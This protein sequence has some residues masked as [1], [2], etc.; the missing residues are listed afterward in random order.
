VCNS[1]EGYAATGSDGKIVGVTFVDVHAKGSKVAVLG[2][3]AALAPGTGKKTFMAACAHAEKL[4]FS[5][6]IL[7][8]VASNSR[9]FS[10]YA[11][12]GFEAK[13]T[14][15]YVGGFLPSSDSSSPAADTDGPSLTGMT[16]E[17]VPECAELFLKAHGAGNGWDRQPE[18]A[19]MVAADLPYAL[20]VAR[21]ADGKMVGYSTAGF[22]LVGHQVSVSQDVF[23][24]MY[25]ETSRLHQER[26]LPC[27]RF[28]VPMEFP[29]L[30][31][32]ALAQRLTVYRAMIIMARGT[33]EHDWPASG[34]VVTPSAG[35][36]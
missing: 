30:L 11:K 2:P 21:D 19:K 18:I 15:Q 13:H 34:M 32:W 29:R 4:G 26:G 27:P 35:G 28:H 9:A 7:M 10:L 33:Y 3:V 14:C 23:C 1:L 6:L 20:L 5:T 25:K 31:S 22:F 17:D 36:W 16:T 8:Q 24:A 12:L